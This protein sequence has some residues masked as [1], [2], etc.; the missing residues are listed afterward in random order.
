MVESDANQPVR[1]Q[2]DNSQ[3]KFPFTITPVDAETTVQLLNDF[4]GEFQLAII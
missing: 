4:T 3:V 1:R 2:D